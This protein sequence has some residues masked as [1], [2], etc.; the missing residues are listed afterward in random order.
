M[1]CG[2]AYGAE[3]E[4]EGDLRYLLTVQTRSNVSGGDGGHACAEAGACAGVRGCAGA[5]CIC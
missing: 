3:P 5:S 2:G 4:M 1:S